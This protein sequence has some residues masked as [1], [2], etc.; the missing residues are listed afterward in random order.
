[1]ERDRI[2][3]VDDEAVVRQV[4]VALLEHSGYST[5]QAGSA[6]DALE[7][8]REGPL[9]HVV[10]SDVMMPGTD[11]LSLLDALKRDFPAIPVVLCSALHDLHVV[12]DAF[13]RGAFDYLLKP[14]ER[15]NLIATIERARAHARER[16]RHLAVVT[17]VEDA[18][19]E[20]TEELRAAMADLERS[21]D[22]TLEAMGAAL[23]LR[24]DVSQGHSKR[25]TAYSIALARAVGVD[26]AALNMIARGAFLHDIGKLATP[27]AILLK[28]DSLTAEEMEIMREHCDR[29]Y[30]IVRRIPLLAEASEIVRSHQERFDGTGYPLGLEGDEIPLGARIFAVADTLDAITSDRP[31]RKGASFQDARAEIERCAGTQFDPQIVAAFLAL[32]RGLW[33]DIR[34]EVDKISRFGLPLAG[35]AA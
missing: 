29:G 13:R 15:K 8:L 17:N 28:P 18:V 27:D 9:C 33:S 25:V 21:Y 10:M 16:R 24:E 26:S 12:T 1:M 31:Y 14:F 35:A 34:A 6:E 7:V 22:G 11:G 23:D 20:R 2:L 30:E 3:V 4:V 32:P 19:T 5:A